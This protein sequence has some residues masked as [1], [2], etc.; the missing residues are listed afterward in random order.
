MNKQEAIFEETACL[1]EKQLNDYLQDKLN[2]AEKHAVEAHIAGCEFCSDALQGLSGV[3]DKEKIST[4]V[5]QIRGQFRHEL[6]AHHSKHK[7]LKLYVWLSVII[8]CIIALLL[9]AY[10]AINYTMQNEKQHT[11]VP[12]QTEI[13]LK[14]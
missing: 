14:N 13:P 5:T 1:S 2:D 9:I 3:T 10:F 8:L 4:I 7:K 12:P 6:Y 11:P